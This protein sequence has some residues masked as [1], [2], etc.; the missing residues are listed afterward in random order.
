MTMQ[1]RVETPQAQAPA[2]ADWRGLA[3]RRVRFVMRRLRNEVMHV[4]VRLAD[5]NGPRGG[6][7]QRCQL[8]LT[9]QAH[10]T[11]VVSATQ[12]D[13][14]AALNAAL[15]RAAGALV[16]QW[17]RQRR[18]TRPATRRNALDWTVETFPV[19]PAG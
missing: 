18:Q 14:I 12:S 2:P 10:G 8:S 9:T 6:V 1:I 3:E 11:L 4:H 15:R 19:T 13:P 16:R 17:Q 5:V 7:D